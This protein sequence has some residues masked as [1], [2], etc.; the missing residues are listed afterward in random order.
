MATRAT[1]AM[2]KIFGHLTNEEAKR[3]GLDAAADDVSAPEAMSEQARV[4]AP[5]APVGGG[6]MIDQAGNVTY[7]GGSTIG[8][9]G[10]IDLNGNGRDD[11]LET[12]IVSTKTER[13]FR[14]G[15]VTP[16]VV[17][18]AGPVGD[19]MP[20]G[21]PI[22]YGGRVTYSADEIMGQQP[23]TSQMVSGA[24]NNPVTG[25]ANDPFFRGRSSVVQPLYSPEE[26]A[27]L[28]ESNRMFRAA[29]AAAGNTM[30]TPPDSVMAA[31][32]AMGLEGGVPFVPGA[33]REEAGRRW[34][35]LNTP[36]GREVMAE[37]GRQFDAGETTKRIVAEEGRR[38]MVGS[39]RETAQGQIGS[40]R[41]TA[42]GQIGS[43]R[44]TAQGQIGSAR[45]TARG[46]IASAAES[47]RG[48]I[49][50]ARETAGG[51]VA[52]QFLAED[53]ANKRAE[54]ASKD[55]K[56]GG[57]I[58]IVW[59]DKL[60]QWEVLAKQSP[61]EMLEAQRRAES[62]RDYDEGIAAGE[63]PGAV[64]WSPDG[65]MWRRRGD[66]LP[67]GRTKN[68]HSRAQ[69]AFPGFGN[70]DPDADAGP[71]A[72][73]PATTPRQPGPSAQ[74]RGPDG[75]LYTQQWDANRKTWVLIPVSPQ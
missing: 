39:A 8:R 15:S 59:N 53:A 20:N 42:Q 32:R 33:T 29:S 58:G 5:A 11:R 46:Q 22:R 6:R 23:V 54:R 55:P 36:T 45:E 1:D 49:G 4:A 19:V 70:L 67:D 61:D 34:T 51:E 63:E 40:A 30:G 73:L 43:A 28:A 50:A 62:K 56:M 24:L 18:E 13:R 68:W 17:G 9:G 25:N 72:P 75:H 48:Q 10:F 44:E 71:G 74:V 12:E 60:Q 27:G 7:F 31:R 57:N 38:G 2:R 3:R 66:I 47:A 52:K 41:E 14:P 21:T 16:S 69:G 65:K 35:A 26:Q 64:V 37:K